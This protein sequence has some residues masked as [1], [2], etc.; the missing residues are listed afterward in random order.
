MLETRHLPDD[1]DALAPDTSEIRLLTGS[2]RGSLAHGT[3]PVGGVSRAIRHRVVEEVWYVLDGTGQIWRKLGDEES[4]VDLRAG[5]SITIPTGAHFQFRTTGEAP[6]R[7]I[8]TTMPPWPGPHEAVRV[9]DHWPAWGPEDARGL[10]PLDPSLY[11]S[12]KYRPTAEAPEEIVYEVTSTS[13]D[14]GWSVAYA[15]IL[16]SDPHLHHRT[17]E[18]YVHLEGPPLAVQLDN[19][20]HL[21]EQGDSIDIPLDVRHWARSEGEGMARILVT[22]CPAWRAED[23]IVVP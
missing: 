13:G 17:R 14:R 6:L 1:V 15:D 18:A 12:R 5:S 7:F 16:R 11:R 19:A 9:P 23:H 2:G 4:V 3:L 8:M 21:L 20:W 22:T 10:P